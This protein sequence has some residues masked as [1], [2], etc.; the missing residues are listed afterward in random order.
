[1][2]GK[3]SRI[4]PPNTKSN[5]FAAVPSFSAS[6]IG[7]YRLAP[8]V[9]TVVEQ[10]LSHAGSFLGRF[11]EAIH[12]YSVLFDSLGSSYGEESEERHVVEQQLLSKEI[13]NVLAVICN[14][15]PWR[16]K[17]I[18]ALMCS[19]HEGFNRLRLTGVNLQGP[20]PQRNIDKRTNLKLLG[21]PSIAWEWADERSPF[22]H[23]LGAWHL[24]F[25]SPVMKSKEFHPRCGVERD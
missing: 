4:H 23:L 22:L 21:Q 9:V 24:D 8:K 11:V 13:R 2:D 18:F 25:G 7:C 5:I 3:R 17:D 10:D 19:A 6:A 16:R 15:G 14:L 20:K 1:M 12:Y